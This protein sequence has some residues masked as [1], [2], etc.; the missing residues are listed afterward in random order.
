MNAVSHRTAAVATLRDGNPDSPLG[1]SAGRAAA[2]PALQMLLRDPALRRT[3]AGR[4]LLRM[5]SNSSRVTEYVAG[6]IHLVPERDLHAFEE[7]AA[8]NAAA[9]RSLAQAARS[10]REKGH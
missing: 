7:L 6:L 4:Q 10:R 3:D 9:W 8:A 2:S 5:L 1:E